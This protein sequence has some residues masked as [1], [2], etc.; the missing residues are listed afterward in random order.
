MTRRALVTVFA[1]GLVT[2]LLWTFVLFPRLSAIDQVFDLNGFGRIGE[3]IARGDGFRYEDDRPTIRRAP[4][5]PVL[6]AAVLKTTGFDP[7]DR[8]R[9]YRP[10]IALQCV[11]FALTC[12]VCALIASRLFGSRVGFLAGL[13]CSVWP[14]CLRY[15]GVIDVEPLNILLLTLLTLTTVL[16]C[17]QPSVRRALAGGLVVGL[18]IL[19]KPMPMLFPLV[20]A[21]LLMLRRKQVGG[22]YPWRALVAYVAVPVVLCLPWVVRN[23]IVSGGRFRGV[24]SN[25]AGEFLRGYVNVQPRFFL[26]R[27]PFQGLWDAEANRFENSITKPRGLNFIVVENGQ[28]RP[29]PQTV[30]NEV[31]RDEIE[32]KYAKDLVLREPLGVVRKFAIQLFT[33]WYIVETPAKS[34][35]VGASAL[36]ALVLAAVGLRRARREGIRTAPV[37][38]VLAYHNLLYA[39][40]LALARY[41]MPLFPTLLALSAYGV[42]ALLPARWTHE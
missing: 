34:L 39:I 21:G 1:A 28:E 8:Q 22:A 6:V 15:V 9:S 12:V 27:V 10:L 32:G 40:L 16:I 19:T 24:S 17:E 11:F 35:L 18:A 33:F 25:A 31:M 5:Y 30:E 26:L 37:V 20:V 41:S 42:A 36:L 3:H 2:G 38:A 23:H 7:M 29:M 13:L 4:L 14:Q